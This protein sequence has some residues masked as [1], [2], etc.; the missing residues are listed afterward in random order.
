MKMFQEPWYEVGAGV[1]IKGKEAWKV[2][3]ILCEC[4]HTAHC[5]LMHIVYFHS[6]MRTFNYLI[7]VED[8]IK[9]VRGQNL[10]INKHG[11]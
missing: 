5:T 6:V 4:V 1:D 10:Q 8:E 3:M 11:G 9:V 7:N 2:D